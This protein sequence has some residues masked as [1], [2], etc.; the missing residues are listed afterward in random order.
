MNFVALPISFRLDAKVIESDCSDGC[1][2]SKT[3][4]CCRSKS[5]TDFKCTA[6]H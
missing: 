3:D 2:L 6:L 1:K 4:W 5:T